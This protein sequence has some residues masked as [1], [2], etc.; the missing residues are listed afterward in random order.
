MFVPPRQIPDL[1]GDGHERLPRRPGVDVV[2]R[3]AL[4]DLPLVSKALMGIRPSGALECFG[5]SRA[6]IHRVPYGSWRIM[7][8]QRLVAPMNR[9]DRFSWRGAGWYVPL[10]APELVFRVLPAARRVP[11]AH[12]PGGRRT[13][14]RMVAVPVAASLSDWV[15]AA[16][17]EWRRIRIIRGLGMGPMR[18]GRVNL[19]KQP[20]LRPSHP[21]Q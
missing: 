2:L 8:R 18:L 12:G 21:P 6:M 11:I 7:P 19:L 3:R 14:I 4:L 10:V 16:R 17:T 9:L 5:A 13:R 15:S 1:A 20:S